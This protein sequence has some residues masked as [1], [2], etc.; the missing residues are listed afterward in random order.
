MDQW[1]RDW[2]KFS[3]CVHILGE[4]KKDRGLIQCTKYNFVTREENHRKPQ[5]G[6]SVSR[7][8]DETGYFPNNKTSITAWV[9]FIDDRV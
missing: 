2:L 7:T 6:S 1:F 3:R 8:E 4:R 9:D 5:S